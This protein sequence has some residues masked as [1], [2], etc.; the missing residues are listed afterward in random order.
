MRRKVNWIY[1]NVGLYESTS[2]VKVNVCFECSFPKRLCSTDLSAKLQAP[3]EQLD[4]EPI[5]D[6]SSNS[7]ASLTCSNHVSL[8]L[9]SNKALSIHLSNP[10]QN[11]DQWPSI[12]C[13]TTSPAQILGILIDLLIIMQPHK[14]NKPVMGWNSQIF[15][16]P[17]TPYGK[18]SCNHPRCNQKAIAPAIVKD[19]GIGV[20]SKYF[21]FPVIS[22]GRFETVTLKRAR[23]V[24]PQ[25]TK[26]VNKS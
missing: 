18:L 13:N 16:T 24:N 1:E 9:C 25:S 15:P 5:Q 12:R 26:K 6:N 21:D 17:Q 7:I 11:P 2:A 20:P 4:G 19:V 23:R 10:N 3:G 14:T 8:G 22:F